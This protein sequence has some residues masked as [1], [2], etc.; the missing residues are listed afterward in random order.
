MSKPKARVGK[1]PKPQKALPNPPAL[2]PPWWKRHWKA[3]LA[4]VGAIAAVIS[5]ASSLVT[6]FPRL[7]ID[8]SEQ[9]DSRSPLPASVIIRNQFLPLDEVSF[10]VRICRATDI[11]GQAHIIGLKS[12]TG[13]S[14]GGGGITMPAWQGHRLQTDEPWAILLGS[15]VPFFFNAGE[16]DVR[17]VVKYWPQYVPRPWFIDLREKEVRLTTRKKPDGQIIWGSE[18]IN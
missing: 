2:S 8:V 16:S 1:K 4:S 5:F 7:Q 18:L 6:F 10:L 11:S 3:T 14:A 9:F 15:N 17:L 12:C 13:A